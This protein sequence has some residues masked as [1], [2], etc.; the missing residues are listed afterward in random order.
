MQDILQQ[1]TE[2][3]CSRGW[4]APRIT[5]KQA[6]ES[7]ASEGYQLL[8]QY[9]NA[10]TKLDFVCPNG[11]THSISWSSWNGGHRCKHCSLSK[12]EQKEESVKQSFAEAQYQLLSEYKDYQ[13]KMD[14]VC[15]NGHE[16]SISWRVW[17][18]GWRCLECKPP[19]DRK[20]KQVEAYFE[21]NNYQLLDL[22]QDCKTKMRV[23][24]PNGH[25]YSTSWT[26]FKAG[27]RCK[28][29]CHRAPISVDAVIEALESEGYKLVSPYANVKTKITI[30]CPLGHHHKTDFDTW[31]N[32]GVRCIYCSGKAP[33]TQKTVEQSFAA[34]GYQVFGRYEKSN[35]KLEFQCASGH[36]G[37]ISWNGWQQGHRCRQCSNLATD[38]LNFVVESLASEGYKLVSEFR[39]NGGLITVECPNNHE[40]VTKFTVWKRGGRCLYCSN[41]API[42]QAD[43]EESFANEGYTLLGEYKNARSPLEFVCPEGHKHQMAWYSWQAG[44][45]CG[46]CAGKYRTEEEKAIADIK[47]SITHAIGSALRNQKLD[48]TFSK[49]SFADLI[50]S[51]IHKALGDRPDGHHL[52]HII[53]RSFFDHRNM[54]EIE[55][56]WDVANLQ[57][58]PAR[59]NAAKSNKLTIADA[60]K[61]TPYQKS[62][63][64]I[65][66][67][68]PKRLSK[69]I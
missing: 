30:E 34:K 24:C 61:L 64:A 68:K 29:C 62:L 3:T 41:Q 8:S 25:S 23:I 65:A 11:H 28:Q 37:F 38:D 12:V 18:S 51:N 44:V 7:F 35:K 56:C 6:E 36:K 32:K 50:A 53:P 17:L 52:D 27:F 42:A 59:E 9:K 47:D 46:V 45:R 58:L 5:Q 16:G 66:S 67:L 69:I 33:I 1:N 22:Y 43:A 21:E 55:A 48:R 4:F 49:S 15:P 13:T 39:R 26:N 10:H 40:W 20:A 19:S 14:F 2:P 31:K 57:W 54:T 63:L 60:Q